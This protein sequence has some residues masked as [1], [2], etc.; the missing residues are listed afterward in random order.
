MTKNSVSTKTKC[1]IRTLG[2][3]V[4]VVRDDTLD[5]SK[6][7]ILLVD[8]AKDIPVS[9]HVVATGPGLRRM[10]PP[11][12]KVPMNVKKG[13]NVYFQQFV[14]NNTITIDDQEYIILKEED[15]LAIVEK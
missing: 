5:K 10:A 1:P 8:S 4:V 2:N 14:G 11:W 7:G 9:G 12:E 6:G 15:V 13:D 3:K